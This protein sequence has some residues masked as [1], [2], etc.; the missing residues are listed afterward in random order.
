MEGEPNREGDRETIPME[1]D[2]QE[3]GKAEEQ[4]ETPDRVLLTAGES[5]ES[6]PED[7]QELY[8]NIWRILRLVMV[9]RLAEGA[10][11][12]SSPIHHRNETGSTS[13]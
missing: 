3:S 7:W 10:A 12:E 4:V 13:S 5:G 1:E 8:K 2:P 9:P 11:L 6:T